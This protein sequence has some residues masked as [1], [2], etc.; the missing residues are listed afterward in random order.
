MTGV[1]GTPVAT[2]STASPPPPSSPAPLVLVDWRGPVVLLTLNNPP[3]NI[4]TTP[5]L[6]ELRDRVLEL[7]QDRRVRAMVLGRSQRS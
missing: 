4:L 2:P 5:L 6:E 1:E 3:L 7:T